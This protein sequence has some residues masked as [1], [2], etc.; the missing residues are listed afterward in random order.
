MKNGGASLHRAQAVF[1]QPASRRPRVAGAALVLA[2]GLWLA[3][4]A[5][6]AQDVETSYSGNGE[7]TV[8]GGGVRLVDE[9]YLLDAQIDYLFSKP[10][11]EAL[12]NGVPLVIELQIEL[13]RQRGLLWDERKVRLSQRYQ[14]SYHVLTEQYLVKNLNSAAQQS[15]TN[16]GA[17]IEALGQITSLPLIDKRLL[18]ED[19]NYVVRLRPRIDIDALPTP[20]RL[21]AYFS[22]QWQLTGEWVIWPLQP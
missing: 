12:E 3:M 13:L 9:V 21:P 20:M 6:A 1:Q 18:L 17:A 22:A 14:L 8:Q 7:F 16:A 2:A 10:V 5:A 4:T 19:E 15:L 11:L